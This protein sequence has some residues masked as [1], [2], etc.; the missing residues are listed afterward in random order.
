MQDAD[1]HPDGARRLRVG[2]ARRRRPRSPGRSRVHCCARSA[3][4]SGCVIADQL[5]LGRQ[6]SGTSCGHSYGLQSRPVWRRCKSTPE[7]F[8]VSSADILRPS[9]RCPRAAMPCMRRW[10][11]GMSSYRAGRRRAEALASPSAMRC[12]VRIAAN[13]PIRARPRDRSPSPA[14]VIA[15]M[16]M[17]SA[18][19][20][21]VPVVWLSGGDDGRLPRVG[22]FQ[23]GGCRS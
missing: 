13:P 15:S 2:Q 8:T 10:G 11:R 20:A 17:N 4:V 22:R 19:G 16:R 12:L 14:G 6:I 3:W 1:G 9:T 18:A 7:R 21:A 23:V 5:C